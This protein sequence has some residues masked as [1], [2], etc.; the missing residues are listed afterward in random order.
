MSIG[1]AMEIVHELAKGNA[2]AEEA[3][4]H[5]DVLMAQCKRQREALDQVEDFISNHLSD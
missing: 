5:E 1:E 2:L 4:Q 3:C